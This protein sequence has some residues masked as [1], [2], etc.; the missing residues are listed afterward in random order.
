MSEDLQGMC[1]KPNTNP[2]LDSPESINFI[3]EKGE[4]APIH[5]H[6]IG[7]V[8]KGQGGKDITEMFNA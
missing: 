8:S 4:N 5:I 3:I 6:P 1:Y 2:P 7:A